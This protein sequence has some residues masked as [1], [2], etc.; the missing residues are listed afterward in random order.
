MTATALT[1]TA[2]TVSDLSVAPRRQPTTVPPGPGAPHRP[3]LRVIEGGRAPGRR[4]Q[5]AV[6]RRRRLAALAL[7]VAVVAALVLLVSAV[8]TR[9]AGGAAPEAA[10]GAPSAVH[11][12][13]PG[14]TLWSI[15]QELAPGAD[16][17]LTVDRLVDLN[18]GAPLQVGQR[19]VLP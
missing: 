16:V 3:A 7:V 9:T 4:A 13:Q 8:L 2:L 12:V 11:V 15:A 6:Y 1:V 18:G 14:E 17:R 19:L 10:A 5:Q